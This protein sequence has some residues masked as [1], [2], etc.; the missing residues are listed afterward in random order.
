MVGPKELT[1]DWSWKWYDDDS[2]NLP[3]VTIITTRNQDA[4]DAP[5]KILAPVGTVPEHAFKWQV[6][7]H[8]IVQIV[9]RAQARLRSEY[10]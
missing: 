1:S 7:P 4:D 9:D 3:T 8:H 2:G 5:A 10:K 6:P